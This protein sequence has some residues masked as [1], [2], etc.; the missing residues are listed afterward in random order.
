MSSTIRT[1]T[2]ACACAAL[3][4]TA[5]MLSPGSATAAPA[6]QHTATT[7]AVADQDAT[8][9][10]EANVRTQ[11][12]TSSTV[13][14]I[15]PEGSSVDVECW[16]AGEPTFGSDRSG[17]MWLLTSLGGWIHSQLVSPVDVPECDTASAPS[18]LVYEDCD[19]ARAA[20]E[21]PLTRSNP[22]FDDH[23]DS[24]NDGVGCE[25]HDE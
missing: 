23:L 19:A 7:Q 17:S 12:N 14:T 6:Q 1:R 11:P 16:T 8:I 4:A 10:V 25:L 3:L 15:L 5:W 24:D 20:G 9:I 18:S 22:R 13:V 2:I 21:A